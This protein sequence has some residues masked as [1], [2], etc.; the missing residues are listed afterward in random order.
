LNDGHGEALRSES[1]DDHLVEEA[2]QDYTKLD[3]LP[4]ECAMLDYAV[5]LTVAPYTASR[6]DI[7][8]LRTHGFDDGTFSTD[9][10]DL[11]L[12]FQ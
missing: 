10:R 1:Q 4:G 11:S 2:K 12:Q 6:E 7:N 5:K 8:E 3:L 9:L